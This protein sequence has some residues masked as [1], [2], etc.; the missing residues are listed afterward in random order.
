HYRQYVFDGCDQTG[1][2]FDSKQPACRRFTGISDLFWRRNDLWGCDDA[3]YVPILPVASG[4]HRPW[5]KLADHFHFITLYGY[6]NPAD[7]CAH[8]MVPGLHEDSLGLNLFASQEFHQQ[9]STCM[10][11]SNS[12][13]ESI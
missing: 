8:G 3:S 1:L 4:F 11:G 7:V 5:D 2:E 12:I 10:A 9:A 13:K 6:P